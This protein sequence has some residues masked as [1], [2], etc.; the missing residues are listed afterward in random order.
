MNL[1]EKMVS[2]YQNNEVMP[3]KGKTEI[4]LTDVKTGKRERIESENMVTNAVADILSKNMCGLANYASLMPLKKMFGGVLLFGEN[5][6]ENADNYNIPSETTA[7]CYAW[8]GDTAHSTAN[9]YRGNPNGGETIQTDNSIMFVWDWATNQGNTGDNFIKCVCLTHADMGNMGTKPFDASM[10]PFAT[11]GGNQTTGATFNEAKG[12][13]MP[14]NIDNGGQLA[15]TVWL[16]GTTF[17]ETIVKHD[18]WK[19]GIVRGTRDW[20]VVSSRTATVSNGSNRVIFDDDTNYYI[21]SATSS[22]TLGMDVVKKSDMSVTTLTATVS[23]VS[24]YT[25]SIGRTPNSAGAMRTFAYDGKY[26]YWPKSDLSTFIRINLS[27]LADVDEL[28]GTVSAEVG[29][30]NDQSYGMQF[31]SPIVLNEGIAVGGNYLINGSKV[32]P[33]KH[34]QG[35]YCS[36]TLSYGFDNWLCACKHG[37]ATYVNGFQTYDGD[38]NHTTGQGNVLNKMY[39]ATINNLDNDV[40]KGSAQTM[41]VRYT[42]T[43]V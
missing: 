26:L 39:L 31:M 27:N 7:P 40:Q 23:G 8:A 37:A 13:Q 42:L 34:V 10:N 30:T 17:K 43:E 38:A 6:T 9:P 2:A 15:Y 19:F 12:Q 35:I 32:Y 20:T 16:S 1:I 24:L 28:E 41:K 29:Y 3:L 36:T 18:Y 11:F 4:E 25:G 33:L 5:L 21:V 14:M 22:T